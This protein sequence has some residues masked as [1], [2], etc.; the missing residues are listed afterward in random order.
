MLPLIMGILTVPRLI[1]RM[2]KMD[3]LFEWEQNRQLL[4]ITWYLFMTSVKKG[5]QS[6]SYV[7]RTILLLNCDPIPNKFIIILDVEKQVMKLNVR[8]APGGLENIL[9][10]VLHDFLGTLATCI[11]CM[12]HIMR[13]LLTYLRKNHFLAVFQLQ[14]QHVYWPFIELL[15]C[16][17]VSFYYSYGDS[18]TLS[19]LICR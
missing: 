9:T 17:L 11:Q 15:V 12:M 18:T 14:I 4:F 7:Y 16:S 19:K 8:K 5:I 6:F 10:W 1:S 2:I 13:T 3:T